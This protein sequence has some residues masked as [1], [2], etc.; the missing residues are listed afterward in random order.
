M[1]INSFKE[2]KNIC[3]FF[4]DGD[5]P[6][7]DK[8]KF[9]HDPNKIKKLMEKMDNYKL[10][11]YKQ[12]QYN[13]IKALYCPEIKNEENCFS[14]YNYEDKS[15]TTNKINF[16]NLNVLDSN[17]DNNLDDIINKF[18]NISSNYDSN[19]C[20]DFLLG[21]CYISLCNKIHG[22]SENFIYK[23]FI[24]LHNK[25]ITNIIKISNEY[26]LTSDENCFK[27][28]YVSLKKFETLFTVNIENDF[29]DKQ[30]ISNIFF[31]N[32]L[33]FICV[34]NRFNKTS[35]IQIYYSLEKEEFKNYIKVKSNNEKINSIIFLPK[36]NLFLVFG[37]NSIEVFLIKDFD[38]NL[39]KLIP[40]EIGINSVILIN[41]IF[42]CGLKSGQVSLLESDQTGEN[43]FN[44]KAIVKLHK[45]EI[46]SMYVKTVSE[47]TH[48]LITGGKDKYFKVFNIEMGFIK[49]FEV[50]FSFGVNNIFCN[51]DRNKN[52]YF[53]VSL[54]N[55]TIQVLNQNCEIIFDIPNRNNVNIK[56]MG[57]VMPNHSKNKEESDTVI[58]NDGMRIECN[59]WKQ[60]KL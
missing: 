7:G 11:L 22:Y 41:K 51:K 48:Y 26:F 5:C 18:N 58:L 59:V 56:R 50:I 47:N 57:I 19:I 12:E 39:Y 4:L 2:E 34:S 28:H 9:S 10:Q 42:I 60:K 17:F 55:G 15:M 8:C 52:E 6:Y 49:V 32:L 13:R 23:T 46:T 43:F 1:N 38:V 16:S 3:Y 24:N 31:S 45:D 40:I 20:K 44:Q 54:E 21:K 14:F 33:I 37:L 53:F 35:L 29:N 36:D 25:L 27:I 30:Y